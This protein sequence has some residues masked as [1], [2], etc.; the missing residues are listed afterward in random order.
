MV[1]KAM[2]FGFNWVPPSA[3]V[4]FLGG[5][6]ETKRFLDDAK[7]EIPAVLENA[8]KGKFYQL[9]SILDARSLLRGK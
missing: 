3:M 1:D 8:P 2:G 5:V 6:D 7:M 9:Q 4:D